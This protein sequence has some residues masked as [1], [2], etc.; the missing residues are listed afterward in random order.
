MPVAPAR[1]ARALVG[2]DE[3]PRARHRRR[4]EQRKPFGRGVGRFAAEK[5]LREVRSHRQ[6]ARAETGQRQRERRFVKS[7]ARQQASQ[8]DLIHRLRPTTCRADRL[9]ESLLQRC[10]GFVEGLQIVAVSVPVKASEDRGR[11]RK[12]DGRQTNPRAGGSRRKDDEAADYD[13]GQTD[14]TSQV[15]DRGL[16]WPHEAMPVRRSPAPAVRSG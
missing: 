14:P 9:H 13:D 12:H 10:G 2:E 3:R 8:W 4:Q 11:K 6:Q 5:L 15:R 1:S 16:G 7:L